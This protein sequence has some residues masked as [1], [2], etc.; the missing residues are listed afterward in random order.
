MKNDENIM[1]NVAQLGE[2]ETLDE[3]VLKGLEKFVCMLYGEKD[4]DDKKKKKKKTDVKKK[5]NQIF[6]NLM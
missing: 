1:A 4:E 3:N 2:N 6:R 5:Q